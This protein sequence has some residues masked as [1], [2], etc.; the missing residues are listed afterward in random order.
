MNPSTIDGI[1][2]SWCDSEPLRTYTGKLVKP[3]ALEAQHIDILDVAH[4]LSNLCRFNGHC[5]QFYSVAE[6]SV[7]VS[8]ILP[9][10]LQLWGLLHDAAEAYLV[11]LPRAVKTSR[12]LGELYRMAENRAMQTL[13]ARFGLEWP[14]PPEVKTADRVLLATEIRDLLS[15]G[16]STPDCEMPSALPER[17]EPWIPVVAREK[18]LLQYEML[19]A[20]A[21]SR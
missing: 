20:Q 6:H 10:H 17:I 3:L 7:R 1:L 9:S 8:N 19:T 4:G 12:G 21:M 13:V 5:R 11:D 18:F 16:A 14:E 2:Q 15:V